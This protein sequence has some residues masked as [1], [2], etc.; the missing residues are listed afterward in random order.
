M[1]EAEDK[2]KQVLLDMKSVVERL[3][4]EILIVGAGAIIL[5]FDRRYNIEGRNTTDID[6]AVQVNNWSDFQS[7]SA[8][9]TQVSNPCFQATNIQHKF[10]HISTGIEVDIVPFGV[11]GE[12]NQEIQWSDGNQMS[13]LGFNEAFSTAESQF[14]EEI[15]F[16]VISLSALIVLKL[17]AWSDRK[18]RKDLEDVYFIIEHYSDDDRVLTKL[19]DELS[20]GLVEYEEAATFLLGCDINN[21]FTQVTINQLVKI[22]SQILQKK[23]TLFPQLISRTFEPDKWDIKFDAIVRHFEALQRGIISSSLKRL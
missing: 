21:N 8:E 23:D 15:E 1:L 6:F 4:L 12:P 2:Q 20:Q 5:V 18:A 14:I 19:I 16:K 17:I 13:L 3:K 22:L 7:L 9:M 10:I 11:I